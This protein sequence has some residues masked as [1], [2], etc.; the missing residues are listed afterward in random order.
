MEFANQHSIGKVPVLIRSTEN[1]PNNSKSLRRVADRG[2]LWRKFRALITNACV[3]YK[4]PS[5]IINPPSSINRVSSNKHQLNMVLNGSCLCG[6]VR[7]EI[8]TDTPILQAICHCS[9]CQ[10]EGGAYAADAVFP[11]DAIKYTHGT[12]AKYDQ[13][14]TSGKNVSH[15]FCGKC[16]SSLAAVQEVLV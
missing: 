15:Y 10:H 6:E 16:G 13:A 11:A 14:G 9:D 7:F 4:T 2:A 8:N 3:T 12:P 5:L 1:D